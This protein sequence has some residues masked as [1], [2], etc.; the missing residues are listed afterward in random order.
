MPQLKKGQFV[1]RPTIN[2]FAPRTVPVE[3]VV[4][5]V[6]LVQ[7]SLQ[8]LCFL[9]PVLFFYQ[10]QYSCIRKTDY[11]HVGNHSATKTEPGVTNRKQD[12]QCTYNVTLRCVL[13]TT[14]AVEKQ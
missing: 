13:A 8:A 7:V 12:R 5:Q 10:S 1:Y 6:A 9:L 14:F 3:F 2:G 4:E 11:G